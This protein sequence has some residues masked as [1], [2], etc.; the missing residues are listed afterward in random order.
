MNPKKSCALILTTILLCT[1]AFA[2]PPG[3]DDL[4]RAETNVSF[5]YWTETKVT[6]PFVIPRKVE[7]KFWLEWIVETNDTPRVTLAGF[8]SFPTVTEMGSATNGSLAWYS[9][10]GT[11]SLR[12]PCEKEHIDRTLQTV[13][14][15]VSSNL[16]SFLVWRGQTN[17]HYLESIPVT[18]IVH[19][20]QWD[21]VRVW[22]D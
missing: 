21:K 1:S 12:P 16:V 22:K 4:K 5:G 17:R 11:N 6:E 8:N 13:T 14:Q 9:F 2:L 20:W 3:W 10:Y 15:Y 19:H 7:G 18:N